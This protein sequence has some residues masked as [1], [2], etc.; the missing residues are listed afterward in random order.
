LVSRK[1]I[2]QPFYICASQDYIE[3]MGEPHSLADL[4]H[5]E[6]IVSQRPGG[7]HPWTV[8][9]ET[10]EQIRIHPPATHEIADGDAMLAAALAGCG[11]LQMPGALVQPHI[12]SGELI[13]VLTENSSAIGSLYAVWP[14]TRTLL[15]K[16]RFVV[17]MLVNAARTG[18]LG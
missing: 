17:D 7:P 8:R 4:R 15:P 3:R 2:E 1:L 12:R 14:T 5:H 10:G 9:D 13:P 16:V 6:C 11:L 18:Q